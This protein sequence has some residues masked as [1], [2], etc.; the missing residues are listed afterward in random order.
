[1]HSF[2]DRKN[3]TWELHID[4]AA[5]RRA[6]GLVGVDLL[7]LPEEG[8]QLWGELYSDLIKFIDTIY[9]ICKPQCDAAKVS[10]EDFGNALAGECLFNAKEA[11]EQEIVDFF[12]E[13]GTKESLRNV[14]RIGKEIQ[15]R[16]V[17]DLDRQLQAIDVDTVVK[18]LIAQSGN[19]PPSPESPPGVSPSAK[20]A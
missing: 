16:L 4:Y 15:Q 1:M 2:R 13:P 19:T 6:R 17:A 12:P 14:I 3:R 5:I 20:S 10:D 11:F 18:K 8:F 9:A 7:K